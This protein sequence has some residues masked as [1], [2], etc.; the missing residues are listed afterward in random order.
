MSGT[1]RFDVYLIGQL[2]MGQLAMSLTLLDA[3]FAGI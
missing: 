2:K 3:V 1:I